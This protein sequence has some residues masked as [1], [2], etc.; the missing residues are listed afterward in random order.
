MVV[1]VVESL[2][3]GRSV[4]VEVVTVELVVAVVEIVVAAVVVIAAELF[5]A[6]AGHSEIERVIEIVTYTGSFI[7]FRVIPYNHRTV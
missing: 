3:E 2:V 6:P 4:V 7:S 5:D 1:A